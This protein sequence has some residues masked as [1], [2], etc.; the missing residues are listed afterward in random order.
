MIHIPLTQGKAALVDDEDYELVS[1]YKWCAVKDGNTYYAQSWLYVDGKKTTI[2]MHRIVVGAIK[3][4]QVDHKNG[5]GLDN[6]KENL[7]LCTTTQNSMN[8]RSNGG[9]SIYKGVNW[10]KTENCWEAGI[11]V[12]G[13]RKFLGHFKEEIEA[14]KAYDSAALEYFGEF[15]SINGVL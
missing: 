4:Q 10:K 12:G 11:R 6:C 14:A 9:T 2:R 7:R 8:Q 15:A 5:N 1:Q 3:G 13:K